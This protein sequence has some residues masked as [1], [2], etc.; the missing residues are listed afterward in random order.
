MG[1]PCYMYKEV[2]GAVISELFDDSQ[3]PDGWYED[4]QQARLAN[5]PKKRNRKP[6]VVS[7]VDNSTGTNQLVGKA[8]GDISGRSEP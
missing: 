8:S 1:N 7:N 3:I 2:D 4:K 5:V 6:K